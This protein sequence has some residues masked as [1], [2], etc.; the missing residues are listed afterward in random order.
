MPRI[1]YGTC[2]HCGRVTHEPITIKQ[3][4]AIQEF[5]KDGKSLIYIMDNNVGGCKDL[6]KEGYSVELFIDTRSKKEAVEFLTVMFVLIAQR[7]EKP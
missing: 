1:N 6:F 2:P 5:F 4:A 7:Q 3:K